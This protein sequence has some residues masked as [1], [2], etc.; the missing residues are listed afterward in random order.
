ME[1][2]DATGILL[3]MGN[4]EPDCRIGLALGNGAN[5]C[6]MEELDAGGCKVINTDWGA[7]GDDGELD[8]WRTNYDRAFGDDGKP[9]QGRTDCDSQH[10]D[11][12]SNTKQKL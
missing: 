9:D 11:K 6:Y 3:A 7:F 8:Q 1:V 10:D 12:P 5:A 4:K 2:S